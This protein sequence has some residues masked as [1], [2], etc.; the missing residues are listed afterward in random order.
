MNKEKKG[1]CNMRKQSEM[2]LETDLEKKKLAA[3]NGKND[4][5][6]MIGSV[7]EID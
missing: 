1:K 5:P 6:S 7:S 2:R 4:Q 3:P